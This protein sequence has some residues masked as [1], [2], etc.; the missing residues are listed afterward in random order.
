MFLG[1]MAKRV[2]Y[3][4]TESH[5]TVYLSISSYQDPKSSNRIKNVENWRNGGL[6]CINFLRFLVNLK[7]ASPKY[8]LNITALNM[9][10]DL[11][12][13]IPN[14]QMESKNVEN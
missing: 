2:T 10:L 5:S 1:K 3:L 12:T 9:Q 7:N 13:P 8:S 6:K 4:S 14:F 11:V